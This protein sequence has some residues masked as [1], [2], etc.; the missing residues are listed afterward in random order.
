MR[1]DELT[2][3]DVSQMRQKPVVLLPVG[4]IEQHGP[5]LPLGADLFQPLHV[6]ERVARRTG[7]IFMK[8]GRAPTTLIIRSIALNS[9]C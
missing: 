4:A 5:H 8:L 9:E 3:A 2:S 7:A 6:L 1:L